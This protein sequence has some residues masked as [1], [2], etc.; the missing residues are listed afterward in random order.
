MVATQAE[1][2]AGSGLAGRVLARLRSRLPRLEWLRK[3]ATAIKAGAPVRRGERVLVLVRMT[4][5][6]IAAATQHAIYYCQD[7][8][9]GAGSW[10]RLG[11]E[12]VGGVGWDERSCAMTLTAMTLAG[13]GNAGPPRI[14]MHLPRR[15]PLADLA[16]ERVTWT[17]LAGVP[18][19]SRGRVCGRL[20]ARRSPADDR[21]NW[22]F[23]LQDAAA[24]GDPDLSA[25]VSGAIA[26]LEAELG[27]A[28]G[29]S[30]DAPRKL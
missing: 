15:S 11:W 14:V 20:T 28:S 30:A 7:G 25:L 17:I 5:G 9:P 16:R 4:D 3:T 19:L 2:F 24:S 21:V 26:E 10:L 22:V 29:R 8:Q 12:E 23:T 13:L 6:A 1:T 18:V 27:P